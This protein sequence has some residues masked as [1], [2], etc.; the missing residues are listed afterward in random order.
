[1]L[2][3]FIKFLILSLLTILVLDGLDKSIKLER[4]KQIVIFALSFAMYL[5]YL[6]T[7]LTVK[8]FFY[9]YNYLDSYGGYNTYQS[10]I[11][12]SILSALSLVSSVLI[13]HFI[14]YIVKKKF[15]LYLTN[16]LVICILMY[17]NYR[18]ITNKTFF[19]ID[20]SSINIFTISIYLFVSIIVSYIFRELILTNYTYS[21]KLM[22][23]IAIVLLALNVLLISDTFKLFPIN[24]YANEFKIIATKYSPFKV[25]ALEPA[26][27]YHIRDA[28]FDSV[29]VGDTC[30]FGKRNGDFDSS[31]YED[32]EWIVLDKNKKD[33]SI[34]LIS[35]NGLYIVQN[36]AIENVLSNYKWYHNYSEKERDL[37][38]DVDTDSSD[39]KEDQF[40]Y[41]NSAMRYRM[42]DCYRNFLSTNLSNENNTKYNE[43]NLS[44]NILDTYLDDTKTT[45]K[46]FSLS[47]KEFNK[48][49]NIDGV[50]NFYLKPNASYI[51]YKK[52][53]ESV[54][55][56]LRDFKKRD[57]YSFD[58][59]I[60]DTSLSYSNFSWDP[61]YN[62]KIRDNNKN[63]NKI[64]WFSERF[65]SANYDRELWHDMIDIVLRPCMWY[66]L[67]E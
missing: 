47:E 21:F 34:L 22:L 44:K 5:F 12:Y 8:S 15:L 10:I 31:E 53:F 67:D 28:K 6:S 56:A 40:I 64:Y 65:D 20:E 63:I 38:Y 16:I 4:L 2:I 50:G 59:K 17:F 45:E 61:S 7:L 24:L 33:K 14:Y 32:I 1:M 51:V 39:Y 54:V 3:I 25:K 30:A 52:E 60:A 29:N 19:R 58:F 36:N 13:S 37:P 27:K 11:F 48:Y 49:K 23:P 18:I 26:K 57:D 9:R 42:F 43:L 55:Y 35:K 66:K 46:F 62:Y 41:K